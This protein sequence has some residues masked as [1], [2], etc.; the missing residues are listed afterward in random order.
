MVAESPWDE[1][2]GQIENND[3][4]TESRGDSVQEMSDEI[5]QELSA[6]HMGKY[7]LD[8]AKRTAALALKAQMEM[9]EFLADAEARAKS[10]KNSVKVIEADASA[11]AR[12]S[13]GGKK[14]TD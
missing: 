8:R 7:D 14:I 10:M 11:D 2:T 3:P 4:K 5:I 9:A 12:L 13:G 6:V 1:M